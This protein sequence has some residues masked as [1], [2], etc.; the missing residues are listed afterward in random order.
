MKILRNVIV[1]I[2]Y[3]E[4]IKKLR[5]RAEYINNR[6]L[7]KNYI[8]FPNRLRENEGD[9]F[10]C[11]IKVSKGSKKRHLKAFKIQKLLF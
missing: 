10:K 2:V 3:D 4:K 7:K 1:R 11:N 9:I 6:L 5:V 8:Q